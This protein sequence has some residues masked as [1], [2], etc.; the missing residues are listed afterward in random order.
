MNTDTG[1]LVS[2]QFYNGLTDEEKKK[3]VMAPFATDEQKANGVVSRNEQC[4]C[5]SGKVFRK[6]CRTKSLYK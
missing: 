4:P 1:E 2:N 5:G 6:C 3:Y